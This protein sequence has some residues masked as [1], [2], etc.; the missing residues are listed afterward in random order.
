VPNTEDSKRHIAVGVDGSPGSDEALC[1]A[2][3]EASLHD[4]A[5]DV[6]HAWEAPGPISGLGSMW[7]PR[8]T[9]PYELSGQRVLDAATCKA[10]LAAEPNVRIRPVLAHGY[11]P[12]RVLDEARRAKMVVVGT[13]GL[14]GFKRL[15][16]GSTS[17]HCTVHS[18]IPIAVVP[19]S[20]EWSVKDEVLVGIDGSPEA[21][22]A[23]RWAM[24]EAATR[25][26]ALTVVN[27]WRFDSMTAPADYRYAAVNR[28]AFTERSETML[29]EQIE[30]AISAVGA[31]PAVVDQVTSSQPPVQALV[32]RAGRSRLLVV[33]RG[34]RGEFAGVRLGSVSQHCVHH[35]RGVVVVVPP[36]EEVAEP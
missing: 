24:R 18:R 27:A 8:D 31:A 19:P 9:K 34:G 11:A 13:R 16:L 14:S 29:R 4:V 33:G 5:L 28:T 21:A 17:H 1:W 15:T 25:Q 35:A 7:S 3:A 36:E 12:A 20:A 26:A 30:A 2:A 10:L 32:D 23:L 22:A 6:I